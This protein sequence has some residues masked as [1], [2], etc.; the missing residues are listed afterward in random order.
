MVILKFIFYCKVGF[1]ISFKSKFN[2]YIMILHKLN[3]SLQRKKLENLL[4][5]GL[6]TCID[7]LFMI[8]FQTNAAI[9]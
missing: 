3:L 4:L 2:N 1:D 8:L 6:Y 5:Y 9:P 7:V